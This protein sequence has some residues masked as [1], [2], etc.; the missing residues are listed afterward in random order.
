MRFVEITLLILAYIARREMDV[1]NSLPLYS[2]GQVKR[3]LSLIRTVALSTYKIYLFV[4][5]AIRED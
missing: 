5:T 1:L 4:L 2:Q 3:L